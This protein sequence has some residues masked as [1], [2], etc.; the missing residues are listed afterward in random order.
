MKKNGIRKLA[1][2]GALSALVVL[3]GISKLGIIP[4]PGVSITILHIPV[5]IGALLEGPVTGIII[6]F[7]FG[8]FSLIQAAMSPAGVLDPFFVNPLISI[9]PRLTIGIVTWLVFAGFSKIKI[10]PK[11]IPYAVAS[12]FG[13][14]ANTFFVLGAL[15]LYPE[16]PLT[17]EV[18]IAV[19]LTN[20]IAEAIAAVIICVAVTTV[21]QQVDNRKTSHLSE[22]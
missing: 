8:I 4:F 21:V 10:F 18:A 13:S 12:F 6:G 19:F 22:E 20:G 5:I 15:Y 7:I 2:T 9:L 14:L 11:V 16:A 3:L 17:L 1:V